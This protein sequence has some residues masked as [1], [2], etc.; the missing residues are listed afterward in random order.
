VHNQC[1]EEFSGANFFAV[2]GDGTLVTPDSDT[3][4]PGITRDSIITLAGELGL[5]VECRSLDINEVMDGSHV[6][7]A[8]CT[9]NAAVITPIVSIYCNGKSR[10]LQVNK[11]GATKRLWDM[12]VGI[13]LQTREDRFGW[14]REIG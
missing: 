2:T 10:T 14:V 13:Q 5:K 4:L 6:V 11:T 1:I 3:V 9:G 7:E 8:F 12:L